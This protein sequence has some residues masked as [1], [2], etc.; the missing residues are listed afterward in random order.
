MSQDYFIRGTPTLYNA[1]T[2]VPQW[3]SCFFLT[4]ED[5]NIASLISKQSE[6]TTESCITLQME[7]K[8]NVY[9]DIVIKYDETKDFPT[10]IDTNKKACVVMTHAPKNVFLPYLIGQTKEYG[11]IFG[12][13]HAAKHFPQIED[14][15][16]QGACLV[17]FAKYK[18]QTFA[19]LVQVKNR[20]YV[21]S[22]AGYKDRVLDETLLETAIRETLEETELKID[23]KSCKPLQMD[24]R[25]KFCGTQVQR[26]YKM[27]FYIC[28]YYSNKLAK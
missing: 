23:P 27:F 5:E 3:C 26:L 25:C 15:M 10:T 14:D 22:P 7:Y 16:L 9:G 6:K 4:S 24:F 18:T 19:V 20:K 1:R 17:I 12:N 11:R 2:E 21:M 8:T 13:S 28:K